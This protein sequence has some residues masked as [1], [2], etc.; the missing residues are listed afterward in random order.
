MNL[1]FTD[2]NNLPSGVGGR[3]L[4]PSGVIH[5]K[6]SST[7]Q[8]DN[9]YLPNFSQEYIAKVIMHEALHACLTS[10]ETSEEQQHEDIMIKY[11]T[12]MATSLQ[13]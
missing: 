13:L 2:V 4:S 10:I 6:L 12:Q 8:L 5:G 11:V 7:I 1:K 9:V 3:E